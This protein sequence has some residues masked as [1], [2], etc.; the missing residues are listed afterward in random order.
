MAELLLEILS[1]EIP[2]RMQRRA[3]DDLKRLVTE[4]LMEAGLEFETAEAFATPRRLALVVDGLPVET[5]ADSEEKRGPKVGAPNRAIEG[6]CR[7][8]GITPGDLKKRETPGGEYYFAVI[9]T[10]GSETAASL[11]ILLL[12]A[13]E[14]LPWPK[15]MRWGHRS[16]RWVRPIRGLFALFD[17]GRLAM[18]LAGVQASD[19]TVGHRFLAP[20]PFTANSFKD[21]KLKL[22][23]AKVL[24]DSTERR[25]K[26]TRDANALAK[27]TA[28]KVKPDIALLTEVTGLVEWPVAMMGSIDV[29]F[30]DLPPEVMTAAMRTHQKY[31]ALEDAA[32]NLAPYFITIAN[33]TTKDKGAAVIAGNERVLRARLADARFY[34]DQDHRIPLRGFVPALADL[35]FHE[36]LGSLADKVWR[37][38]VLTARLSGSVPGADRV[39]AVD[40]ARLCKADLNSGIVGE[41]PE[42]QGIMGRY[43]ALE[44]G[45][46]EAVADAIAEHYAPQGPG[47]DC[48]TK[49]NSIAVA[50]ADKIDTLV[51]FWGID[52]KPTGSRDPFALRRAALGVIR[53]VLESEIRLPLLSVFAAASNAHRQKG[54]GNFVADTDELS[55]DL[56]SF[57]ED[58]LKV[59][60]RDQGVRHDL[61]AA[62]FALGDE[63]DLVRLLA[64]VR[65]L[66]SFLS[67]DDGANLLTAY[68]RAAN[69]VRIEQKKDNAQFDGSVAVDLLREPQE[70]A[71]FDK[72]TL[73]SDTARPEI[74]SEHFDQA[75]EIFA[76]LRVSVDEFFDCVTVNCDDATLRVNRLKL[77]SQIRAT[78][79]EV[80][81]FSKI[82][83]GER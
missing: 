58:R 8:I 36:K 45:E 20:K 17:G 74:E 46:P 21:Y 5:T 48:P 61:I 26:I 38:E 15:P 81:D 28:L 77:L 32:G 25:D 49:P 4:K 59:H 3:T 66:G 47:D 52:E 24:L 19:Q 44:G 18:E 30:M 27:N 1:E 16:E 51:G 69:I 83:G 13:L 9:E 11:P 53:L 75:M 79:N 41:F 12:E 2:A 64:R 57:V 71:L 65:A 34:W 82:E 78:L 23:K 67:S 72:L 55:C 14:D 33:Q 39:Q 54:G 42:L 29:E 37:M 80:A 7:G 10:P 50:L 70:K 22:K 73:A 31:F 62:V 63:D 76:G 43:Y 6:F 60:L 35:V 56:L 40:A 68:K